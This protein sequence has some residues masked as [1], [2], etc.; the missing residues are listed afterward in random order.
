[1]H[2]RLRQLSWFI[3]LWAAGVSAVGLAGLLIRT[4]LGG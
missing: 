2:R 1:M 4:V 3:G